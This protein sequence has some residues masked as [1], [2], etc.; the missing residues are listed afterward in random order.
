[1]A[2]T[3]AGAV[4][5]ASNLGDDA[6]SPARSASS[7]LRTSEEALKDQGTGF[8][9]RIAK[10]QIFVISGA[11]KYESPNFTERLS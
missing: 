3:C 6:S 4:L 9:K 11:G 5:R 8:A 2:S 7:A 10:D 1:M